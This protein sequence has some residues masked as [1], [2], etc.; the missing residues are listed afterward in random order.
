ME[1]SF[2]FDV[3]SKIYIATDTSIVEMQTYELCCDMI[4]VSTDISSIY[5]Y[6]IEYTLK[7]CFFFSNNHQASGFD[8]NTSAVIVL[9]TRQIIF[10]RQINTY[11]ALVCVIKEE[12]FEKQGL[13]DFNFDVF[14][15]VNSPFRIYIML[16]I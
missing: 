1:K 6:W 12:N 15:K 4:D 16:F 14:K 10:M 7:D 5:G 9:R 2:L 3:A 11:L 13:I 8:L